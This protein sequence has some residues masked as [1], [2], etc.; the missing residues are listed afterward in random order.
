M[1]I[2]ARSKPASV[3]VSDQKRQK[4]VGGQ[5]GL[6]QEAPS[7]MQEYLGITFGVVLAVSVAN[8]LTPIPLANL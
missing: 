3:V 7:L 6:A 2:L 8:P 5:R 1:R 4:E